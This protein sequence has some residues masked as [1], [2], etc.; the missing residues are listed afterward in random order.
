[1]QLSSGAEG[2]LEYAW[3]DR[4]GASLCERAA[5]RMRRLAHERATDLKDTEG[6]LNVCGKDK[7]GE[8]KFSV[9]IDVTIVHSS[10]E[11]E[12]RKLRAPL[13]CTCPPHHLRCGGGA[14][15]IWLHADQ[16][17]G[18]GGMGREHSGRV[19]AAGVV[20][21][22]CAMSVPQPGRSKPELNEQGCAAAR[23]RWAQFECE[24]RM[25]PRTARS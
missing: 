7:F 12:V 9:P 2:A 1:M 23:W 5:W 6:V 10:S 8:A 24:H 14:G 17:L 11:L 13:P 15:C 21:W 25:Q 22:L 16:R 18:R 4:Y 20:V 19:C 3:T